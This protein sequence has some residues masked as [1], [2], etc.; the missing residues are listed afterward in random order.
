M[1]RAVAFGIN[2]APPSEAFE[3]QSAREFGDEVIL[4]STGKLKSLTVQFQSYGCSDGGHWY[5]GDCVTADNATF[6]H[7]I[8]ARIYAAS[9]GLLPGALL[10]T[11][12]AA[13]FIIPYRPSGDSL[14][15]GGTDPNGYADNSRWFNAVSGQCQYSIG[16]QLTFTFSGANAITLPSQVIWT[17]EFNTSLLRRWCR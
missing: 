13:T 1:R 2:C 4:S 7:P 15:C 17:V 8:T 9:S 3:A 10:A 11:S 12:D 6:S 16:K 5:S 14:N